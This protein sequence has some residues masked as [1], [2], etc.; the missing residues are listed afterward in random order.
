MENLPDSLPNSSCFDLFLKSPKHCD[1]RVLQGAHK[2]L[3]DVILGREESPT[4]ATLTGLFNKFSETNIKDYVFKRMTRS[5]LQEL[6]LCILQE[7]ISGGPER[8]TSLK[9]VVEKTKA[10]GKTVVI[11]KPLVGTVE[12]DKDFIKDID[13]AFF[14]F[15][16]VTGESPTVSLASGQGHQPPYSPPDKHGF[17]TPVKSKPKSLEERFEVR[18]QDQPLS[19]RFHI[20]TQKTATVPAH[21][22]Q[23][24]VEAMVST[25]PKF[26][27]P[28]LWVSTLVKSKQPN[29]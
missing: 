25:S 12:V 22:Q 20:G 14:R 1:V 24:C 16:D 6:A 23:D 26:P 21:S 5:I 2:F 7:L 15:E 9:L 10:G 17:F 29:S 4:C 28:D 13:E 19:H 27:S 3:S 8:A 11:Q 18:P